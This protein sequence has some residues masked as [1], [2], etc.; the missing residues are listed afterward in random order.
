MWATSAFGLVVTNSDLSIPED[1]VSDNRLFARLELPWHEL[2]QA[3]AG[4]AWYGMRDDEKGC[5]RSYAGNATLARDLYVDRA[6]DAPGYSFL[7]V[8]AFD[9][10]GSVEGPDEIAA[11]LRSSIAVNFWP[12]MVPDGETPPKL[13]VTVRTMR[14]LTQLS[15]NV[16]D[17]SDD[18]APLVETLTAYLDRATVDELREAGDVVRRSVTLQVPERVSDPQ[19]SAVDEE[20]IVLIAQ[21][22]E[23]DDPA[24]NHVYFFRG[25]SMIIKSPR[26]GGL[27]LGARPF[28]AIVLAGEAAGDDTADHDA[29]RFLRAAEPPAH[30]AWTSTSDIAA[31]YK[32]GGKANLDRMENDSKGRHSGRHPGREDGRSRRARF[33]QAAV[34][35][36]PTRAR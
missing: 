14:G 24:P 22:D 33:T 35:F 28:H 10:S 13:R 17:P 20:V 12:A 1:D 29:E 9:P 5:T 21:A 26:L 31:A 8:A 11:E 2:N 36:G 18:V 16:V 4:P 15:E 27:P 34:A 30:N 7:I 6:G 3:W 19:H 23:Q 25:N 32:R